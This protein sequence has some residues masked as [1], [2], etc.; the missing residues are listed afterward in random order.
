MSMASTRQQGCLSLLRGALLTSSADPRQVRVN[1]P[2]APSLDDEH[3]ILLICA[4]VRVLTEA[5]TSRCL[6]P[7]V[8]SFLRVAKRQTFQ[9]RSL[10]L[11]L[12]FSSSPSL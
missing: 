6:G 2:S 9:I 3:A 4:H 12:P 11:F 1:L 7:R 5:P 8:L 10:L